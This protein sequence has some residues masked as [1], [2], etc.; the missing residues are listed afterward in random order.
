MRQQ[1]E[2]PWK[3]H[4]HD[5]ALRQEELVSVTATSVKKKES[6]HLAI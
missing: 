6:A 3:A 4:L 1:I 5:F 2:I